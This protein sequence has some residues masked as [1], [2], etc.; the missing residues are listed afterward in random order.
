MSTKAKEYKLKHQIVLIKIKKNSI[1][2][3]LL[4]EILIKRKVN[5]SH[6]SPPSYFNH[7]NFVL[8]HPYRAWYLVKKNNEFVG[9][10]YIL[11]N[12]FIGININKYSRIITPALIE[13]LLRKHKP[14]KPIKSVRADKFSFNVAPNDKEYISILEKM[15]AKL[16][17]VTYIFEK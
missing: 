10:V 15:G 5:I 13:I 3:K 14:L 16:A 4:Y 8:N 12:N 9:N 6:K 1:H 2:T 17:Q 11:K 7:K